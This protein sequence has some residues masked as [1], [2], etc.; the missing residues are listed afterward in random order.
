[1]KKILIALGLAASLLI[2]NV[3]ANDFLAEPES[4]TSVSYA[5]YDVLSGE[6]ETTLDCLPLKAKRSQYSSL[7]SELQ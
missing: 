7:P 3:Y 5:A 2:G 1:M 4:D 6:W